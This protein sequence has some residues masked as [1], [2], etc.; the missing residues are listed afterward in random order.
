[1]F[2]SIAPE[3]EL[4]HDVSVADWIV[5]GLRPWDRDRIRL[6]SFMPEVFEAYVRVFHPLDYGDGDGEEVPKSWAEIGAGRGVELSAD[7]SLDDV[8]GVDSFETGTYVRPQG[9]PADGELPNEICHLLVDLLTPHTTTPEVCWFCVWHGRGAFQVG[10]PLT[11]RPPSRAER[12]ALRTRQEESE[13]A[14][15]AIPKVRCGHGRDHVLFKGPIGAA[16]AFEDY[17]TPSLWWPDDRAWTVAT[18]IDGVC[19]YVGGSRAAVDAVLGSDLEAIEVTP[20]VH[21]S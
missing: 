2:E 11:S 3:A 9:S 1:M 20:D 21:M 5:S 18:E 6:W 13:A 14:L 19:T 17:V 4:V 12:K 16:C 10:T 8:L 15:D 7:V